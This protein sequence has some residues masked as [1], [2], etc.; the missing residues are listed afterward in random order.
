MTVHAGSRR[1]FALVGV[2]GAAGGLLRYALVQGFP[3]PA[4]AFPMTTLSI[5]VTGSFALALLVTGV[6]ARSNAPSWL[7]PTLGTGL[8]GGFTTFSAVMQALDVL[9]GSGHPG[10]AAWYLS[11]TLAAGL[12]A[13]V[14][15]VNAGEWWARRIAFRETTDGAH[16]AAR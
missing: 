13:A 5:N 6:S 16:G 14:L 15:G 2:G 10:I 8:L 3:E 7:R 12:A 1:A 11:T 9:A 4:G